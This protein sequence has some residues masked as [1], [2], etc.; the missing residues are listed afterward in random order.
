MSKHRFRVCGRK[1]FTLI[2]LLV[3]IAIIAI[4]IGMLLPAVQKVR[5]A[6]AR[7]QRDNALKAIGNAELAYAMSNRGFAS[8]LQPLVP[9]G[10][11]TEIA[12][13]ED[14]GFNFNIESVTGGDFLARAY[15]AA[16]GKTGSETCTIMKA[17]V[18]ACTSIPGAEANQGAMFSRMAALGAMQVGVAI[19]QFNDG[20]TPETI[21]EYLERRGV[22]EEAFDA[23]DADHDGAFT[24]NDL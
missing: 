7:A 19:L 2:E 5:E 9:Y 1:G 20:V 3:V 21:R 8:T 22:E 16:V 4:L 14:A 15:P 23:L 11:S 12:D 17:L 24:L 10:L 6:A 18:V 13:G